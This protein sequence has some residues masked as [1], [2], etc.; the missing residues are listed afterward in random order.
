MS[1]SL[2]ADFNVE[3]YLDLNPDVRQAGVDP[4]QH[5]LQHGKNEKRD[6]HKASKA[7]RPQLH[8]PYEFDGLNSIHN[9]DF[10]AQ[11]EFSAA[12][13]RGVQA[14]G[15]DYAW[16]WRVHIGLWAAR[17]AVRVKGD[18]VECG[19]NFGFLSSAIMK[20]LDW[21][22]T[23]RTFYLLDTFAGIDD[24]Y[25]SEQERASG[26]IEKSLE[27]IVS[28]FYTN[29]LARVEQNFSE[30][31]NKKIVVGTVPETLLE[32]QSDRI[33][34]LHLDMNNSLPEVA[35]ISTL[36]GKMERGGIVLLDDYAYY[37]FQLQKEGMDQWASENDVPIASLPTGQ[38]LII[39]V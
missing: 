30:W 28:G 26:L 7:L 11:P 16:Y 8:Q 12:Y 37:G 27:C 36:W 20:Y 17:S 9:H 5:Y 38:G 29:N 22:A 14:S 2:P 24:R 13:A 6:Y 35:A 3:D 34:F 19:V 39:K 23:G 15:I 18:F 4:I 32:I 1:G 31:K 21:D 33:A 10:M 25:I